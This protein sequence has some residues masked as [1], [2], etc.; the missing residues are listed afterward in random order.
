[1]A[2]PLIE[3]KNVTKRFGDE[4]VLDGVNL[5]IHERQTTTIIGKSGVGKS[6][7]LKHIVGLLRPDEGTVLFQGKSFGEMT[8]KEKDAHLRQMSYMFQDNALFDS[9]TVFDNVALPLEQTTNMDRE[10][11][12]QRVMD[13]IK[14]VELRHAVDKYPG[15]LSEGMQKRVA[16]SRALVT[17]PKIVFFD[18]PATGQDPVRRN[19]ILAMIADYQRRLG[20]TALLV[21][22]DIPDVFFISNQIVVLYEGKVVFQGTLK[23]FDE[24]QHPFVDEFITSLEVMQK[25]L[26][27]L[28]SRRTFK[29]RYQQMLDQERLNDHFVVGVFSLKNHDQICH[30]LGHTTAQKAIRTLGKHIHEHFDGLGG[31]ST[32]QSSEVFITVLPFSN[33]EEATEILNEFARGLKEERLTDMPSDGHLRGMSGFDFAVSAGLAEGG[34]DDEI[35]TLVQRARSREKMIAGF[36][37]K[38]GATGH[39]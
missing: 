22:H 12:N 23:E 13:R 16:L 21:S 5:T 30:K 37:R 8:N 25:N 4:T 28:H 20:F 35:E 24:F 6:V 17:E 29:V 3:F 36:E 15:Q 10:M 11:I 34:F 39:Y 1:M 38:I 9:M 19:A 33:M 7:L 14:E 26:S 2:R 31:F 18:E 27:G 32:R